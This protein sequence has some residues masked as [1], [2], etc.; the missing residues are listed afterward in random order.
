L[1]KTIMKRAFLAAAA[2]AAL[3]PTPSLALFSAPGG[4]KVNPVGD[5]VYEVVPR[6][7]GST[8]DIWCG[9]ADYARR[10]LGASWRDRIYVVR[11][12]GVSETTGKR[13]SVQFTTSP[14]AAGVT[15]LN[16]AFRIGFQP[17]DNMSVQQGH[18]YCFH[19]RVEDF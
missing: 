15:P 14:E 8:S 4:T 18:S 5:H 10:E 9:A 1:E 7:S 12:R 2:A 6:G 17:G 13:S 3:L 19:I 11:G 16:A